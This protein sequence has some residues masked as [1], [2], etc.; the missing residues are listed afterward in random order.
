MLLKNIITLLF[1]LILLQSQSQDQKFT[2][3]LLTATILSPGISYEQPIGNRFTVKMT[4]DALLL[5]FL[6]HL[7]P[8]KGGI[9]ITF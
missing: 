8:E 6:Q 2:Q 7:F 9:I 4:A 3:K 1:S 5:L